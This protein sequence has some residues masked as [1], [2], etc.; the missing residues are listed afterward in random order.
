MGGPRVDTT[1]LSTQYENVAVVVDGRVH[2]VRVGSGGREALIVMFRERKMPMPD[3]AASFRMGQRGEASGGFKYGA[4]NRLVG[5]G[6]LV[7]SDAKV[8]AASGRETNGVEITPVGD[9][10]CRA[11]GLD[12]APLPPSGERQDNDSQDEP[13]GE[14]QDESSE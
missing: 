9:A 14:A 1:G 13:G 12:K 11:L 8:I 6:A 10:V 2:Q 5:S 3:L 7:Y 4:I